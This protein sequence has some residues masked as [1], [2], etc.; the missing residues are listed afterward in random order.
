MFSEWKYCCQEKPD[1]INSHYFCGFCY[2]R[3]I[4]VFSPWN[5]LYLIF[6]VSL[7][8]FLKIWKV[9]LS[10]LSIILSYNSSVL[11][12][13]NFKWTNTKILSKFKYFFIVFLQIWREDHNCNGSP[14][15]QHYLGHPRA[16]FQKKMVTCSTLGILVF[17]DT[18]KEYAFVLITALTWLQMYIIHDV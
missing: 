15:T 13:F 10:L 6:S 9:F 14:L 11:W 8:L 3:C 16:K 18:V 5:L 2:N 1:F 7:N 12:T 4:L 17:H